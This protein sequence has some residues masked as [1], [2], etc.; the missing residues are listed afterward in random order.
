MKKFLLALAAV[1]A[2]GF[3]SYADVALFYTGETAPTDVS[4]TY[5][6][7]LENG[8]DDSLIG[9]LECLTAGDITLSFDKNGSGNTASK[10]NNGTQL[11]WYKNN[12][13]TITPSNGAI[14]TEFKVYGATN[15]TYNKPFSASVGEVT[16]PTDGTL[17]WTGNTDEAL[18][19]T[20]SGSQI[21]CTY[22]TVTYEIPGAVAT[23]SISFDDLTNEVTITCKDSEATIYYTLDETVPSNTSNEYSQ[24]FK[25]EE[26][27]TVKAVAILNSDK[28]NIATQVCTVLPQYDSFKNLPEATTD[29]TDKLIVKGPLT[30][31]YQN[32]SNLY[33]ADSQNDCMLIY[34]S[35]LAT[36]N[37]GDQIEYVAGTYKL[38]SNL[39]EITT[40]GLTLGNITAGG[41]PVEPTE[42][43][44]DGVAT[45]ALN[46]YV[47]LTGVTLEGSDK[48]YT[49]TADD[50][51]ATLYNK[52]N[53][54]LPI[55]E[56]VEYDIIG[57]VGINGTTNEI[58]P[59]SVLEAGTETV[60]FDFTKES[61]GLL[62][63]Y[64]SSNTG[65]TS[66]ISKYNVAKQ[67]L[68]TV[69]F[70][71]ELAWRFWSDGLREYYSKN[72]TFTVTALYGGK[73]KYVGWTVDSGAGFEVA[74][75]TEG[76]TTDTSWS[77]DAE[78][79]TFTITASTVTGKA[80]KALKTI[81]VIYEP[82]EV[83]TVLAP[84]I[85][86]NKLDN[87]VTL[88]CDTEDAKIYYTV[89]G[90]NPTDQSDEYLTPFALI[91]DATVKAIAIKDG[92][93]SDVAE[94]TLS[95]YPEFEGYA[96]FM[97][98]KN[99]GK[100]LGPITAI[101]Q[102]GQNLFTQDN[103]GDFMLLYGSTSSKLNNG[104]VINYIYGSYKDFN[105]LPE[106]TLEGIGEVTTEGKA[107]EPEVITL[108]KV[109]TNPFSSYI[110]IEGVKIEAATA[111]KT[112]TMTNMAEQTATLYNTF[113]LEFTL[114]EDSYYIVEGF[115]G[116]Y[117]T[118]RQ[119][120]PISI[121]VDP[122]SAIRAL[123]NGGEEVEYYNLQGVKVQ[124][125]AKGG[126]YIIRKGGKS[127]KAVI[128]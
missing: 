22:L 8:S 109:A 50:K 48:T 27:K 122:N 61:Y 46:S 34:G 85:A 7:K 11:R 35:G 21:Q 68:V 91:T 123:G 77:G 65:N 42:I 83:P 57:F 100:V 101:Y 125:P 37:N 16:G 111:A 47:K 33:L 9:E 26:T 67:D 108:D 55:E 88:T 89:D 79:V 3:S 86:Y 41:T 115:I 120:N 38:Y 73:V 64:D 105:G 4:A 82:G 92:V 103:N 124:N 58:N 121:E 12:I 19:L 14:I 119:V 98:A 112:F 63:L 90:S 6:S 70:N 15:N 95:V 84:S 39:P 43:T 107:I 87:L 59:I 117:N 93:S 54:A 23:P 31:V 2:I 62:P 13:L 18:S 36:L 75:G 40:P 72:P 30:A 24:P 20:A 114:D 56:G 52:F 32:G 69:T 106:I 118:N 60:T 113:N 53:I 110:K 28:S 49:M 128:R 74:E 5:S 10:V 76:T 116:T 80:N 29:G 1:T 78:S 51:N 102:N 97:E 81:T 44:V 17:T 126:L 25:I 96:K 94:E 104:D 99:E 45:A 71:G 66:Y 127:V